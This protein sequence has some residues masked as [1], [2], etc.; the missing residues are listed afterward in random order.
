M[1]GFLL[2][3]NSNLIPLDRLITKIFFTLYERGVMPI[4]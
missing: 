1:V 3:T 4:L 2:G